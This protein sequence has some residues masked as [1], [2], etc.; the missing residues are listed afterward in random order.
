MFG[1]MKAGLSGIAV[2]ALLATTGCDDRNDRVITVDAVPFVVEGVYSVT[3]DEQVT[4]YWRAN[5][6][7]DIDF[8]KIY[9]NNAPTGTFTLIG[10]SSGTSY[11]DG[12]PTNGNTYYYAVAAVDDAGQESPELSYENVFDTPRPEGTG[13]VLTNDFTNSTASG[14]DF[15]A[16]TTRASVDARTDIWYDAQGGSYLVQAPIDTKIQD[17][18]YVQLRDVDFAPPAGWSADGIVEAIVGHSY[19]VLTRDGNYAKFEVMARGSNSMTI[20]WAYQID[21]DNPEL[22]RRMP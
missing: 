7:T 19:I 14:W 2:L 21:P 15:S 6:E 8:Y 16:F 11:V 1:S 18:G 22:V 4:V 13:A 3:G 9:R 12:T 5:Q 20:D 10:T 17:A